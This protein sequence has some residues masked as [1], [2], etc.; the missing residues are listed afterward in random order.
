[1]WFLSQL[2]TEGLLQ[3]ASM[4]IR[5]LLIGPTAVTSHAAVTSDARSIQISSQNIRVRC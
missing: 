2:F 5:P 4:S 3:K 1:M